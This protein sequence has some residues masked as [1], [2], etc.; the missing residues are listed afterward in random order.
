M[1]DDVLARIDA[2]REDLAELALRLGN[3]YSPWG[4]ER[5]L[6]EE[7][8][9]WYREHDVPA[10]LQAITD[11]RANVVARLRGTGGGRTI[12]FNAHLDTEASGPDYDRLMA[13]PDPNRVGGR[14]EGDR[15]F[16]H[17]ILNDRGP[18]SLFMIAGRA[19]RDAGVELRG[20]VVLTS[21]AGET[22]AAPVDEY[23]GVAYEGKGFGS[24][25]LVRHGVR[26]D[27][28]L[29]AETTDFGLCWFNCGAAYYKITLRG[30]NMYTP[31]LRRPAAL[32][33]HPNAIV[34][35]AHVVEAVE[36][37]AVEFEAARSGPTP[38]GEV[39]PKAQV[40]AIRGGI[41]WRPN[42]SSPYC[43]VYVD[44]R[45]LPGEDPEE[46]TAALTAA[47][48]A[49]GTGAE[50]ELIMFKPGA[51]GE[52]VEPLAEAVRSAHRRVRGTEPPAHVES[53]VVSMWRDTNV[54]NRAG[55]PALTFGP[56][57]GQADVQGTGFFA[58]DDLVDAA[59][60]YALVALEVAG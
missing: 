44:V 45:T 28:A 20:D 29:V 31:R 9:A 37:W 52:G 6:A 48:D 32:G 12:V 27:C 57:R 59:K 16:G 23:D 10:E 50:V 42:R 60:M 30:R 43:A 26:G 56:S 25:Y 21:V 4:S 3:T 11:Q 47:V 5:L 36:A 49:T 41:P 19:L 18:M 53:A 8:L 58:L 51:A 7:V 13:V 15:L 40:G 39:R 55:I 14:R 2:S 34:K 38:C 33:E 22:G 54:F 35:A 46:V 1:I 17:T 24:S